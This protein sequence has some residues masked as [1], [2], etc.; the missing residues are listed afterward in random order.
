MLEVPF[1]ATHS[2]AKLWM[3]CES[4]LEAHDL[5]NWREIAFH[6]ELIEA[7][8]SVDD[9]AATFRFPVDTKGEA[10]RP[11]RFIDLEVPDRHV[12]ALYWD[13]YGCTAAVED[14]A[15]RHRTESR[16]GDASLATRSCRQPQ[17]TR[18]PRRARPSDRSAPLMS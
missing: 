18:S 13:V 15:E 9:L 10:M 3:L 12:K 2:P 14:E 17:T 16:R 1:P 7:L 6:G 5:L 4:G 11:P 8:A